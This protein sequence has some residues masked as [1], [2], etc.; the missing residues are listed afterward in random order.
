MLESLVVCG[1][2]LL[3]GCQA[4]GP[5]PEITASESEIKAVKSVE[6]ILVMPT[7]GTGTNDPQKDLNKTVPAGVYKR[8]ED[9]MILTSGLGNSLETLGFDEELAD[10]LPANW[11]V[12]FYHWAKAQKGPKPKKT[13]MQLPVPTAGKKVAK[14]EKDLKKL[15]KALKKRMKA[16]EPLSKALEENQAQAVADAH[17]K[18]K[19]TMAPVENL[20]RHLMERFSIS[21]L[22]VSWF[23][24]SQEAFDKDQPITLHLAMVNPATGKMRYYAHSTGKKSDLPT[25]LEGLF[26]MMVVNLF[27]NVEEFDKIEF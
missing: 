20:L 9:N 14:S 22:V 21:Y 26:G 23:D 12:A 19:K 27:D 11:E 17:A 13:E 25:T 24:G 10:L 3:T 2:L 15:A 6:K 18:V 8:Y 7:L 1:A 5:K 4:L 16:L